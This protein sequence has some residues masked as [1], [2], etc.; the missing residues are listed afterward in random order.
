MRLLYRN[1]SNGGHLFFTHVAASR[2]LRNTSSAIRLNEPD[3]F[4]H[5]TLEL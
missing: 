4:E 3:L 2:C 1:Y 5:L